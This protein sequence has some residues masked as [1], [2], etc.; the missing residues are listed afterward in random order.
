MQV[1]LADRGRHVVEEPSAQQISSSLF[2]CGHS[3]IDNALI[4]EFLGVSKLGRAGQSGRT[5]LGAKASCSSTLNDLLEK[6][7]CAVSVS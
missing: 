2:F 3:R 1:D 4:K 7:L 5:R 6:M